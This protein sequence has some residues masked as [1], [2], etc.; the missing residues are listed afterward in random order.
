[1][2]YLTDDTEIGKAILDIV[3]PIPFI[4]S[5]QTENGRM[6]LIS[7][8]DPKGVS[9]MLKSNLEKVDAIDVVDSIPMQTAAH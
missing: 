7:N 2:D 3:G 6:H 8:M 4:F 1:M 9:G 5:F